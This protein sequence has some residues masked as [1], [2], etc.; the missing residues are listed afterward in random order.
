MTIEVYVTKIHFLRSY[1]GY[2]YAIAEGNYK[3]VLDKLEEKNRKIEIV[4]EVY[5]EKVM[6][7]E[8]VMKEA[9]EEDFVEI[10]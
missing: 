4:E 1:G 8:K 3:A 6:M 7:F 2:G 9:K 10:R 5:F